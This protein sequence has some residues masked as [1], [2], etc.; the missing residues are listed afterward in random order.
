MVR[1]AVAFASAVYEER[2]DI[3]GVTGRRAATVDEAVEALA[4]GVLLNYLVSP[5]YNDKALDALATGA[6]RADRTI[7]EIDRPQ[8]VVCSMDHDKDRA[9]DNAREL[10]TQ[11]LGQQPHIMKASGVSQDLIDEVG[12]TIGGWPAS[13]EDIEK[14]MHLAGRS[15]PQA[16]CQRHPRTV[17]PEGPGV[18][19]TRLSVSGVVPARRRRGA[20]DRRVRRRLPVTDAVGRILRIGDPFTVS[21]TIYPPVW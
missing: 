11:Y 8:Q 18:R 9:L 2:V 17:P 16:H 7:E 12:D 3:E 15:R 21:Q 6:E 5:E 19:R 10:I 4:D 1:R 13:E 14:G 20:D